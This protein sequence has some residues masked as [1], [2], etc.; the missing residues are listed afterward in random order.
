MTFFFDIVATDVSTAIG[1][2]TTIKAWK[3]L[4]VDMIGKVPM[5]KNFVNQF[6]MVFIGV[7]NGL[8][9][10][11]DL[12]TSVNG[13]VESS[14]SCENDKQ[15]PAYILFLMTIVATYIRSKYVE[16]F[17]YIEECIE[18]PFPSTLKKQAT[19]LIESYVFFLE[20]AAAVLYLTSKSCSIDTVDFISL[21]VSLILIV[22]YLVSSFSLLK[23]IIHRDFLSKGYSSLIGGFI[24]V[25]TIYSSMIFWLYIGVIGKLDGDLYDTAIDIYWIGAWV[26]LFG[27]VIGLHSEYKKIIPSECRV[28]KTD[29]RYKGDRKWD[30]CPA[31]KTIAVKHDPKLVLGALPMPPLAL[32]RRGSPEQITFD[33]DS[34][35]LLSNG[36]EVS[37]KGIGI[38]FREQ[39]E[40]PHVYGEWNWVE[41]AANSDCCV[42]VTYTDNNFIELKENNHEIVLHVDWWIIKKGHGI[43]FV[44][45]TNGK[46][47]KTFQSGCGKD[48]ILNK[49]DGTISPK[50]DNSLVIGRGVVRLLLVPKDSPSRLIFPDFKNGE[51]QI[52]KKIITKKVTSATETEAQKLIAFGTISWRERTYENWKYLEILRVNSIDEAASVKLTDDGILE[53]VQDGVMENERMRLDFSSSYKGAVNFA[54]R[55]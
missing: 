44:K 8:D 47:E 45:A 21:Y 2:D 22:S 4:K 20:D 16:L 19:I 6:P 12:Y 39:L 32:V 27:S 49:V 41:T 33:K 52:E 37:L 23:E 13:I 29:H 14:S 54:R 31:S 24:F 11:L 34:L 1:L 38:Q 53:L 40:K 51:N 17:R 50:Q 55:I 35:E 5:K 7:I 18:R 25:S 10:L 48:W 26:V 42:K 15:A 30:F 46:R 43:N 36:D 28:A 9:T 3:E